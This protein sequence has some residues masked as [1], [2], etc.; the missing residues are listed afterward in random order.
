M[1]ETNSAGAT[2][3]PRRPVNRPTLDLRYSEAAWTHRRLQAQVLH[4]RRQL[5]ATR[6][7]VTASAPDRDSGPTESGFGAPI[8]SAQDEIA[9]GWAE[10][11]QAVLAALDAT[12]AEVRRIR[13]AA[14]AEARVLAESASRLRTLPVPGAARP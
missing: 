4:A 14:E 6:A 7:E 10:T 12:D 1:I 13:D 2:E 8:V 11:A 9:E 5:A 3:L